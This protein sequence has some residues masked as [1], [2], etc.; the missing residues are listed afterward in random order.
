MSM[1]ATLTKGKGS[2]GSPSEECDDENPNKNRG[3][4]FV[5]DEIVPEEEQAFVNQYEVACTAS[6]CPIELTL[7]K[8]HDSLMKI[9]S[10]PTEEKSGEVASQNENDLEDIRRMELSVTS[11]D[12]LPSRPTEIQPLGVSKPSLLSITNI[13]SSPEKIKKTKGLQFSLIP[14]TCQ[15][16]FTKLLEACMVAPYFVKPSFPVSEMV[17]GRRTL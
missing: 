14:F 12:G 6:E 10:H 17:Q 15:E 4:S 5:E 11:T 9:L 8:I 7:D 3:C 13:P 1:I 16:L 2:V